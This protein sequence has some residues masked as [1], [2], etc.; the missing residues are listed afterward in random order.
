M[1]IVLVL[2]GLLVPSSNAQAQTEQCPTYDF[3]KIFYT[4]YYPGTR[5]DNSS[6]NL[7]IT[8][9][10]NKQIIFDE[11]VV[12]SFTSEELVW[13]R[14]AFQSWD[15]ALDSVKFLEISDSSQ[16]NI[17]IGYVDL[18]SAP[19][20]SGAWAYWNAWWQNN[21]R[22][23]ATIKLKSSLTAWFS[24]KS[25][26]IHTLQQ[27]IGNVL[28]LGD[29]TPSDEYVSVFEDPFS[30]PFGSIPLSNFDTGMMR[31]LYGEST[32]PST[33]P[34]NI[35]AASELKA[36]Q[37]ADALAAAAKAKADEELIAKQVAEA[38]AAL[39]VAP[40]PPMIAAISTAKGTALLILKIPGVSGTG[41]PV[42]KYQY[43]LNGKWI[44]AIF[45]SN[46]QLTIKN[47]KSGASQVFFIQAIG[48]GGI[49]VS[50]SVQ[51]K[52]R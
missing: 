22:Y 30:P 13:V 5:W 7:T 44:N 16:A 48:P 40:S 32:C 28:G 49:S 51:L 8:W 9:S 46:H 6:G 14:N 2:I 17:T 26:F 15:D 23:S 31:Q 3:Q 18:I 4:D 52:I 19:N 1:T 11:P 33:F 24:E 45:N 25:Q 37:E 34:S 29:A 10:T 38:A 12:R 39:K 21:L 43:R 41:G 42:T 47:L 35:R 27:E 20:Q 36:R 50:N